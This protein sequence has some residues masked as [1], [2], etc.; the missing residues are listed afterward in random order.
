MRVVAADAVELHGLITVHRQHERRAEANALQFNVAFDFIDGR[1]SAFEI[2]S[3]QRRPAAGRE[4][5]A[6][7]LLHSV[8]RRHLAR[9]ASKKIAI[10]RVKSDAR[11]KLNRP[12]PECFRE[13]DLGFERPAVGADV[14]ELLPVV[15][16]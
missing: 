11:S 15:L 5:V 9:L 8:K 14:H 12:W 1:A 6:E 4:G 7:A 10:V 16:T 2:T 3:V 13:S